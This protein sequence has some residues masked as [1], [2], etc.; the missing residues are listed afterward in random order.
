MG[1]QQAQQQ[2]RMHDTLVLDS[3]GIEERDRLMSTLQ[4][5]G[6]KAFLDMRDGP[7]RG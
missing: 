3:N 4:R 7:F 1:F 5:E 2:H 6:L